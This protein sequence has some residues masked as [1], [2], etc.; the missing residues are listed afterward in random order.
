MIPKLSR[1]QI[2]KLSDISSDVGL[3]FLASVV[4]P[5]ALDKFN[6]VA[7]VLGLTATFIFWIISLTLRR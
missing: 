3:V 4:I 7:V 2:A 6:L 5:A 1:K